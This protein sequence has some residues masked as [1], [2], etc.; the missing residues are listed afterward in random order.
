M[1]RTSGF[2]LLE[3]LRD[4]ANQPAELIIR[5]QSQNREPGPNLPGTEINGPD[6]P[7]LGQHF[8]QR[9]A[10]GRIA[11]ISLLE[12][13]EAAI[14]LAGEARF[15]D[16]KA[17]HNLGKVAVRL[18]QKLEH[19]MLDFNVIVRASQAQAGGGLQGLP[20]VLIEFSDQ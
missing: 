13:V 2:D 1:R 17:I 7:S 3:F 19:I 15:V 5:H 8:D 10:Q 11:R 18:V 4:F 20:G 6:R 9:R 14:Q 16:A 12:F